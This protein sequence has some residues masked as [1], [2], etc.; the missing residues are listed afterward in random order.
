MHKDTRTREQRAADRQAKLDA[1]HEQLT[2]AVHALVSSE[3]WQRAMAFA[4]K[5]RRYSFGNCMLIYSQS[6]AA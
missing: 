1:L 3:D 5:F 4:A 6:L 2:D